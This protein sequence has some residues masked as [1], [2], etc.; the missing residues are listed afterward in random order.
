[1]THAFEPMRRGRGKLYEFKE[2]GDD[3]RSRLHHRLTRHLSVCAQIGPHPQ[4][5]ICYA[6]FPD[7]DRDTWWVID[8]WLDGP[9]LLDMLAKGQLERRFRLSVGKQL[10]EGIAAAHAQQIILR[11]MS[12]ESIVLADDG[13]R[14]VL[15]DFELAKLTD[16]YPTVS[17]DKWRPNEYRAPEIGAG[18][19]QY[20]ADVYSWGRIM[21][22]ATLGEL[23]ERGHESRALKF[24][25][26]DQAWVALIT[27]CVDVVPSHR[28]QNMQAVLDAMAATL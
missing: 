1:M 25:T 8:Q 5:P 19:A 11:E 3:A 21:L 7:A 22:H 13:Q 4:F 17:A 16:D 18:E 23:P 12:A 27:Q 6:T 9:T 2:L 14:V 20:A 28:P 10:A 15:T 24:L 26:D